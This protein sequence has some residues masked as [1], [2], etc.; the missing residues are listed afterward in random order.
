MSDLTDEMRKAAACV[1]L[2]CPEHVA[3]DLS[4]IIIKGA[5][6]IDELE[7]QLGVGP[8]KEGALGP[9]GPQGEDERPYC[10]A[11]ETSDK[12]MKHSDGKWYCHGTHMRNYLEKMKSRESVNHPLLVMQT[13]NNCLYQVTDLPDNCVIAAGSDV[14]L[15]MQSQGM[16]GKCDS[17]KYHEAS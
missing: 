12:M 5:D 14:G 13:C 2:A 1:F 16:S 8:C 7:A 4:K 9:E 15:E 17:W 10:E 11:C 6:R 3:N